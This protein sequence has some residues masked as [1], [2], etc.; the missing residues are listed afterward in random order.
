MIIHILK[1]I[2]KITNTKKFCLRLKEQ[3]ERSDVDH[4][5]ELAKCEA[6]IRE[7]KNR[8]A[9]LQSQLDETQASVAS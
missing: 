6:T 1:L 4:Q 3:R 7:T 9:D 8:T 5:E 2:H